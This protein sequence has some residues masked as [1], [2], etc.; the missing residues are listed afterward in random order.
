VPLEPLVITPWS[1]PPPPPPEAAAGT[2][3]VSVFAEA[4]S[5]E[6]QPTTPSS[7]TWK[8][9]DADPTPSGR[10]TRRPA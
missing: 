7:R 5:F 3:R 1:P 2:V 6:P 8:L 9:M 10:N 4:S